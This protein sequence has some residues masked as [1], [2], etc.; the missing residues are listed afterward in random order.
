MGSHPPITQR[1]LA[2]GRFLYPERVSHLRPKTRADCKDSPRPCPWVGCRHHLY[3]ELSCSGHPREP[4]LEPW[5][6]LESCALDVADRGEQGIP[7][8]AKALRVTGARVGQIQ[9]EAFV[10]LGPELLRMLLGKE[11]KP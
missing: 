8:T 7:A 4:D 6:L 1:D 5:D 3:L 2:I 11:R 9:R 10:K